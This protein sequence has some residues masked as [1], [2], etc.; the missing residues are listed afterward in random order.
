MRAQETSGS[1][2]HSEPLTGRIFFASLI[3]AVEDG[4]RGDH[5]GAYE[6]SLMMHYYP[7]TVDLSALPQGRPLTVDEDG[8]GG[9]DPREKASADYGKWLAETIVNRLAEKVADALSKFSAV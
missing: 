5:A 7:E 2:R 3:V 4:V 8:V 1:L 9:E 6:T